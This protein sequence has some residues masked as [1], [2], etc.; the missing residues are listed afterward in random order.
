MEGASLEI[1]RR[2][3]VACSSDPTRGGVVGERA[4][5][6]LESIEPLLRDLFRRIEAVPPARRIE[7]SQ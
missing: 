7:R 2:G 1:V 4:R 3:A 5:L 6:Y